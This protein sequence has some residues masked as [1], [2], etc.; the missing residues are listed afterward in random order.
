MTGLCHHRHVA[1]H[2]T[3]AIGH[4]VE[5]HCLP[6]HLYRAK[7]LT[8]QRGTHHRLLQTAMHRLLRIGLPRQHLE[9]EELPEAGIG[10]AHIRSQLLGLIHRAG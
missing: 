1:H 10:V 5:L 9:I 8:G 2:G 7:E 3:D 6:H 4:I